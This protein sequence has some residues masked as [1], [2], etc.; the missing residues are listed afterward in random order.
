MVELNQV[1]FYRQTTSL[2]RWQMQSD[3]GVT[4]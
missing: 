4:S 2:P 3:R 1:L